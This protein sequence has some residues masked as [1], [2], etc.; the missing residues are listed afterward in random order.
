MW[1]IILTSLSICPCHKSFPK[2]FTQKKLSHGALSDLRSQFGQDAYVASEID[3][4]STYMDI[5]C[6][7]G[8]DGSNTYY[9]YRQGWYGRCF[10]ADRRTYNK[11]LRNSGRND[12]VNVGISPKK[13]HFPFMRVFDPNNGLSGLQQSMSM[14]KQ[15]AHRRFKSTVVKVRTITPLNVLQ[16]YYQK[17]NT[18]DFVSLDV[19]GGE[20]DVIRA[21]PFHHNWCVR[22][23]SIE[24]NN[25][26]NEKSTLQ[27]LNRTLASYGYTHSKSIGMDYV[28]T[29]HC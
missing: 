2:R 23:F 11:I 21:W 15:A 9:F 22:V 25:W 27:A 28:F 7:D 24:D 18:I 26:C 20:L 3:N 4:G 1:Y 14:H 16:T 17:N 6:N 12:G 10:E 8:I 19:E 29:K 5:G 13:G